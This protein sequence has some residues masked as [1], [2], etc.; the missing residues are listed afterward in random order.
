MLWRLERAL[1]EITGMARATLQPP[2]GACGEMTGL[3][4]MRAY[5]AKRGGARTKVIIPDS[6]HGTNPASVHLAG[7]QAVPVPS[8]AR[9][10][11]DV[12]GSGEA[13]GRGGRRTHADEPEHARPVRGGH[14]GDHA[15]RARRRRARVLRRRQPQRD[16][17]PVPPGRHGL[18]HRA[19]QHAQDVRDAARRGRA[20]RGAGRRGRGAGALPAGADRPAR[21]GDRHVPLGPTTARARSG[22]STASTATSASWCARTPTCSCT[23]PTG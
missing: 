7:F 17:R 16:P 15:D 18:R 12:S 22:A 13:G 14:P 23:A 8:D 2:A 3:L 11:V 19:H 20:G 1:C 9:G 10:L 6:A 4:M 21:R 5:H